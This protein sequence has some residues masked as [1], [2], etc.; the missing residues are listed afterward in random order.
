MHDIR[1][2]TPIIMIYMI[3]SLIGCAKASP[4]I[5]ENNP[6][7]SSAPSITKTIDSNTLSS[8][9]ITVSSPSPLPSPLY[10]INPY[11]PDQIVIEE[12]AEDSVGTVYLGQLRR[13]ARKILEQVG[14][15]FFNGDDTLVDAR[16]FVFH[17]DAQ[18]RFINIEVLSTSLVATKA[19]LNFGDSYDKMVKLYGS[20]YTPRAINNDVTLYRYDIKQHCF[21]V[22]IDKGTV[23]LW[24]IATLD[25]ADKYLKYVR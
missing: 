13:D 7:K 14:V 16:N 8:A 20:D 12:M 10:S 19:G 4:Q 1:K 3:I 15:Y 6:Q 22:R 21:Y 5:T 24:G 18:G 25:F 2:T 17:L 9:P 23:N 11:S